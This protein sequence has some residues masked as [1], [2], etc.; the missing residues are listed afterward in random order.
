MSTSTSLF[1]LSST[2][3]SSA[4][5]STNPSQTP[6]TTYVTSG[7]QTVVLYEG[8]SSIICEK[9]KGSCNGAINKPKVSTSLVSLIL[10]CFASVFMNYI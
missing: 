4:A 6:F 5:T 1:T 2:V 7:S 9:T 10:M 3:N 8:S